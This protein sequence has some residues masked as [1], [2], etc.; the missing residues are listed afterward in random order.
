MSI[1]KS[2]LNDLANNYILAVPDK[3]QK[4]CNAYLN[5]V[6]DWRKD[7]H[8]ELLFLVHNLAGSAGTYGI[9]E[10][11]DLSRSV[12]I[13]L[14]ELNDADAFKTHQSEL[15]AL[16]GQLSVFK[17]KQITDNHS[18]LVL[19]QV[20]DAA[21]CCLLSED[22]KQKIQNMVNET[23]Y[24][25]QSNATMSFFI[26]ALQNINPGIAIV[27]VSLLADLTENELH[28]LKQNH[29]RNAIVIAISRS[30]MF[31]LREIAARID[32]V[33]FITWPISADQLLD[34][35]RQICAFNQLGHRILIID[36][37]I[38]VA[39]YYAR[40]L[41]NHGLTTDVLANV[42]QIDD[43]LHCSSPDLIL[44]DLHMPGCDGRLL[45]HI[46]RQQSVY[47][48]VPIIFL[49]A[50]D[51]YSK[52]LHA[53]SS[54]AD[55]FLCKK[56]PHDLLVLAIKNKLRSYDRL[57]R[58]IN[59]DLLTGEY[60]KHEVMRMLEVQMQESVRATRPLCA[61]L[62]VINGYDSIIST[63]GSVAGDQ[64]MRALSGQLRKDLR[65]R[66]IIGRMDKDS[67]VV[68]FPDTV[69][70][71]A[72]ALLASIRKQ[73]SSITF[74][75]DHRATAASFSASV[76]QVARQKTAQDVVDACAAGMAQKMMK[77]T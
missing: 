64:I 44:M 34:S 2:K 46:I 15:D 35:I 10:L 52:Q 20:D 76:I 8:D 16:F 48:N 70:S 50:E 7:R 40:L 28:E 74:W 5:L 53:M 38:E 59:K 27:D 36:D 75:L 25:L 42:E 33:R 62:L 68:L 24:V 39:E 71:E 11:S 77:V 45:A 56:I 61:A 9:P 73:Y 29:L 17:V 19:S 32:A 18:S 21:I 49:S 4:I 51:E 14:A 43:V 47:E 23:G 55:D 60:N 13:R 63:Y 41:Q 37:E 66:D 31:S 26:E 6:V 65:T 30:S 54:G 3:I 69:L 1:D 58:Y 57:C 12:E 67:F 22:D 72:E